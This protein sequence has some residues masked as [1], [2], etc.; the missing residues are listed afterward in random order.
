LA[1]A[2]WL[3]KRLGMTTRSVCC[4]LQDLFG[5]KLTPGGLTQAL[6]RVA[7]KVQPTFDQLVID[8]RGQSAVWADETS[9]W[10]GG[11]GWWLWTFTA[12]DV[13]VYHV[14]H[15]R[16]RDVVLDML[17]KDF[18]GVLTTD[19]LASYENL[20]Y[21]MHKCYAHHLKAIAQAYED[22]PSDYLV[23]LRALLKAAMFLQAVRGDLS[24]PEWAQKR[25]YLEDRADELLV[26]TT[27][28]MG[29]DKVAARIRK[30]RRWLFTFLDDPSLEATNNRAERSLRP[31]VIARKLSCGNKTERGKHTWETLASLA[32]TCHQRA[33]DFVEVLRPKLILA[34]LF[35]AR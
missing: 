31:A 12:P 24:P 3:S 4:V 21:K 19:C 8:L 23:E 13:T 11:P 29:A 32:A 17:G 20:P 33:Q 22:A 10:V 1:V 7:D 27:P 15:S 2:A 18:A 30:R 6:N 14:D 16:G 28:P 34:P 26:R 35:P 25:Q 5:L 9:W